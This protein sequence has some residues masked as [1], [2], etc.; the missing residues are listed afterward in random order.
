[1]TP[2]TAT[3]IAADISA[4]IHAPFTPHTQRPVSGGD[5]NAAEQRESPLSIAHSLGHAPRAYD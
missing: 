1:M 2:A 5:I 4:A 3:A